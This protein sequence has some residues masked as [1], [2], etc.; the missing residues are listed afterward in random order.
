MRER[1][2]LAS[3]IPPRMYVIFERMFSSPG[4]FVMRIST[5]AF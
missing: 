1:V 4:R 2:E 3:K 5:D